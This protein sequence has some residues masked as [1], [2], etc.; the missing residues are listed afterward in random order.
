MS[1]R[2]WASVAGV[3]LAAL[4]LT[5]ALSACGGGGEGG[6]GN[7]VASLGDSSSEGREGSQASDDAE[8]R[9]EGALKFAQ[10]MR[11]HGIDHPDPDENGLFRI[12]PEQGLDPQ[13]AKFREASEAC[14]KYLAEMGPPPELS[15]EDRKN[16]Q[17]QMLAFA[18][19]MREQ[20][21]DMPD[22]KFDGEGGGFVFEFGAEGFDPSDPKYREAEQAC[23]EYSPERNPPDF[24][25]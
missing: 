4:A 7:E 12:E 19:C 21:I 9:R 23:R 6:A 1:L 18:K 11:E 22:P 15:E 8:D 3:V 2:G 10:C 5:L 16:M 13:S 25:E 20:G 24:S 14:E 17:E